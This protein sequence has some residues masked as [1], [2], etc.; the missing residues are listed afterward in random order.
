MNRF[1]LI[2]LLVST[3]SCYRTTIRNGQPVSPT[4]SP[5]DDRLHGAVVGDVVEADAPLRLD[6]A[7]PSGWAEVAQ[8]RTFFD[9]IVEA[10]AGWVYQSRHSTVRCAPTAGPAAPTA[11]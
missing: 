3:A 2:V 11:M 7:C 1:L 9:G 8:E 5:I 6:T 4:P 10:L